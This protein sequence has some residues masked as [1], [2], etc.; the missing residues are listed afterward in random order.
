M[1]A[2]EE[3]ENNYEQEKHIRKDAQRR[4]GIERL[5]KESRRLK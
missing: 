1:A 3:K 4:S 5:L 2:K